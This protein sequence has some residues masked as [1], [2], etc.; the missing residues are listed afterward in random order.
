MWL[1]GQTKSR[2][3]QQSNGNVIGCQTP[4]FHLQYS[5]SSL[6]R[7]LP[8]SVHSNLQRGGASS[9]SSSRFHLRLSNLCTI[10]FTANVKALEHSIICLNYYY[11]FHVSIHSDVHSANI[12]RHQQ[13]SEEII[14]FATIHS[15]TSKLDSSPARDLCTY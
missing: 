7:G 2:C 10:E 6:K 3:Y 15:V 12:Q 14:C 13:A 9:P 1:V 5:A 11:Y 8:V 4:V